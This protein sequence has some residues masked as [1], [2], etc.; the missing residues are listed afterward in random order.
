MF[1]S[2]H[3]CPWVVILLSSLWEGEWDDR[4]FIWILL[5]P[6]V[7]HTEREKC[8]AIST[9]EKSWFW[10]SLAGNSLTTAFLSSSKRNFKKF[11]T[12]VSDLSIDYDRICKLKKNES[13]IGKEFNLWY[14]NLESAD[15]KI[16]NVSSLVLFGVNFDRH[17]VSEMYI[18]T[19]I[20]SIIWV[21][22]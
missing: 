20:I 12:T 22:N 13:K 8:S 14:A 11:R 9:K 15:A 3:F 17:I 16:I 2:P 1:A 4:S 18:I 21:E 6:V 7:S 5:K 10:K 19:V